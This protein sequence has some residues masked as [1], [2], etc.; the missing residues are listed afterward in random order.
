MHKILHF[1]MREQK[2][3]F[4]CSVAAAWSYLKYSKIKVDYNTLLKASKVCP[5]D[6]LRPE[7]VINLLKKFGLETIL[8]EHKNIRFIKK[9]IL[10]DN[11]VIVLLQGRKEYKKSW[12][13]SW[14]HGHYS[15]VFGFDDRRVFIYDPYIGGVKTFTFDQFNSRWHDEW[16]GGKFIKMVIIKKEEEK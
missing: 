2:Y 12:K 1:P 11:P 9:Q 15:I 3:D 16:N 5:V 4:D 7:K 10:N 14:I 13:N 8:V 6:G